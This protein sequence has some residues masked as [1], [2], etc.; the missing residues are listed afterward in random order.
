MALQQLSMS[1]GHLEPR[2][3]LRHMIALGRRAKFI[4]VRVYKIAS[5]YDSS[6]FSAILLVSCLVMRVADG[7]APPVKENL[8][9]HEG[10]H[11]FTLLDEVFVAYNSGPSTKQLKIIVRFY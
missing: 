11:R 4:F 7:P 9:P 6:F 3:P 8:R 10:K 1:A 2:H 5:E